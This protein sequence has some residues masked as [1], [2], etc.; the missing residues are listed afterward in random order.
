MPQIPS[1]L[2][3]IL[4]CLVAC[5]P[6]DNREH[7]I[8]R[9]SA[10][11]AG[12]EAE[13]LDR[14]IGRFMHGHPGV[15]VER[16]VTP[17]AADERHQL[18]V[19]WLNAGVGNPDILQL[20]VISVPEFAAARWL[21]PLERFSPSADDFFPVTLEAVRDDG[22]L[23]ALPWFVDVGMLYYRTDLFERPP[24]TFDELVQMAS[25][26]RRKRGLEYGLVWQGARYEGLVTVFLEHLGGFGGTLL[27]SKGRASLDTPPARRALSFMIDAIR[28]DGAV[29][30]AVLTWQEEQARF[31]F[32][33]GKA[34]F[35]RNWPYAYALMQD[36]AR[37][38]VAGHFAIAP[39]P[40]E[41]GGAPTATLGGQDLAINAHTKHPA[42]AYALLEFLTAPE[43]MLERARIAGQ[44]PARPS[45]YRTAALAEALK[46]PTSDALA[47]VMH[48][49]PRPVTP[50]YTNLSEILQVE[51]HRALTG[52]TTPKHALDEAQARL[53]AELEAAR[54]GPRSASR[55]IWVA[56][57]GFLFIVLALALRKRR[58]RA[59]AEESSRSETRLAWMLIAPA[60]V[61]TAA[62]ALLPL[63]WS[64]YESLNAD[65]LR[66]PWQGRVFVG[67]DNYA[68]AL[69]TPRFWNAVGRTLLFASVSVG[70]EMLTGLLLAILLHRAFR[71]RGPART[72]ALLPWAIPTV[73]AAL[74]WRFS[75]ESEA[76]LVNTLLRR[77]H[78][79]SG[80]FAWLTDAT[81]AWV[82]VILADVW[83]SS[84]FVALLLLA[85]LESIDPELYEAARI[86]GA[87]TLGE[88]RH[89]TLPLLAPALVVAFIFRA[90]DAFRVF[91]LVYV[92]T[93]G[94]PGTATEPIALYAFDS[95]LRGL[96]FGY[97][98]AVSVLIFAI[99]FIL[100]LAYVRVV[101]RQIEGRP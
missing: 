34:A 46:I 19:Q 9:I 53:T 42:E 66:R 76:G 61:I 65:D 83:K 72:A 82:P 43:Q 27:D 71:G 12:A 74:V 37:S 13:V 30:E 69:S 64:F 84:P 89:V 91:D 70:L 15:R 2:A 86:D 77:L 55:S 57:L 25:E 63:A 45:L 49:R 78:L 59:V 39:M 4:A 32:Q 96:R 10:S 26:A 16:Q 7:V 99:A 22:A 88:L 33:N 51:L 81:G 68:L 3:L 18:Y 48:A 24:A 94:G 97:G 35:M 20:D 58:P 75:F 85:R 41:P 11:S 73:V 44:L 79:G 5:A 14:Q 50:V 95:M 36:P 90:L 1:L 80:H 29:P 28:R 47:V 100:A 87:G 62:V 54:R 56:A 92:L 21:L 6:A 17:D 52:Q 38:M 60:V 101:G 98:S 67:V 31:A 40:A 8:L 93:H 23:Y